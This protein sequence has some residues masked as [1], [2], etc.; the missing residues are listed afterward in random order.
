MRKLLE[1]CPKSHD[2]QHTGLSLDLGTSDLCSFGWAVLLV[3][4]RKKMPV[5]RNTI[6][7]TL[8][9]FA[10]IFLEAEEIPTMILSACPRKQRT[11][12]RAFCSQK[13]FCFEQHL[14]LEFQSYKWY[15]EGNYSSGL[16]P[17]GLSLKAQLFQIP[18]CLI[19]RS[20]ASDVGQ[21]CQPK[22]GQLP[23]NS[24]ERLE[25]LARG[26]FLPDSWSLMQSVVT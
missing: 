21:L 10:G 4:S 8:K 9:G 19:H 3:D 16:L 17:S 23:N 26:C 20:S 15:H 25:M 6:A 1:M 12:W 13:C 7:A 11:P 14:M 22:Q 2:H 18:V 5:T 24:I